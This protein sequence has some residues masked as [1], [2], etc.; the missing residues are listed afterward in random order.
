MNK[1]EILKDLRDVLAKHD[2]WIDFWYEGDT[3]GIHSDGVR[4]MKNGELDKSGRNRSVETVV[5]ETDNTF[6]SCR[7]LV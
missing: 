3:Y 6:L 2:I 5:W 4:I 1:K 7:N